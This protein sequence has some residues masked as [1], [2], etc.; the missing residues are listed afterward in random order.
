LWV[1]STGDDVFAGFKK[2]EIVVG[3]PTVLIVIPFIIDIQSRVKTPSIGIEFWVFWL[4]PLYSFEK[5]FGTH[6]FDGIDNRNLTGSIELPSNVS[7]QKP[8]RTN[9]TSLDNYKIVTFV[10]ELKHLPLEWE[11]FE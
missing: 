3:L 8:R 1:W 5:F 11:E 6:M 10:Y 4:K 9:L 7:S 2:T